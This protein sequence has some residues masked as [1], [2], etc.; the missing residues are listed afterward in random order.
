MT[1]LS[2]RRCPLVSENIRTLRANVQLLTLPSFSGDFDGDGRT[3]IIRSY[4]TFQ[5]GFYVRGADER[6]WYIN[7]AM[8]SDC[9]AVKLFYYARKRSVL[10][11]DF[12]VRSFYSSAV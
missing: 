6:C 11:A 1:H 10:L 3:D 12:F 7:G 4:L 8:P 2:G 9:I 5:Q